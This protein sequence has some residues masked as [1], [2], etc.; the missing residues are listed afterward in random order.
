MTRSLFRRLYRA[1]ALPCLFAGLPGVVLA[2]GYAWSAYASLDRYRHALRQQTPISVETFQ[3]ALH[4]QLDTDLRRLWMAAPPNPSALERFALTLSRRDYQKLEAGAP[5]AGQHPYV[6]AELEHEGQ[7]FAAKVRLRGGRHWH[8]LGIQQSL[9]VKLDKGELVGGHRIFNLLNDPT[10]M[11][12]GEQLSLAVARD[13]G[14]LA[15]ETD[16]AR[17]AINGRDFGVF[18]YEPSGDESLLRN[19]RRMPGSIYTSE[20][21]GTAR[22]EELWSS[23]RYWTKV[24]S[25]NDSAAERADR[26]DL[27]R[28]LSAIHDA[29]GR[30]FQEFAEHELDLRAFAELDA[31]DVAF[32][33]DQRDFRENHRYYFDPYRARWE[34]IAERFRGFHED[35]LFNLVEDPLLLRLK[36]TPG[37]LSLRDRLLYEFLTGTGQPPALEARA[38]ALLARLGPELA[39]DPYW[40]AYRQ[41][42]RSD[43]FHRQ[44][45]R[46][47]T[48]ER[49]GLVVES[50]FTT[51]AHRHAQLLEALERN[52][53]Y[54]DV[55]TSATLAPGRLS[56][57]L[58]LVIDGHGGVALEGLELH[59]APDCQPGPSQLSRSGAEL[60]LQKATS[61][62]LELAQAL[63]LYPSVGI[64]ARDNP[65]LRRG[66]VRAEETPTEYRLTLSTSCRP[67][68]VV[69]WGKQLAS[70]ARVWSRPA[71]AELLARV[72]RER[73]RAEATPSFS[74]G[75]VAPHPWQL[76][77]PP[78][79]AVS[80]GPGD[81]TVAETR[82]FE[83]DQAVTV[84]PGTRLHMGPAASLVFHGPVHFAGRP[85]QPIL[86]SA[87]EQAPWGGIIIQGPASAGSELHAV[88]LTGGSR[89]SYRGGTYPALVDIHDSRDLTIDGCQFSGPATQNDILH[90]AYV[91]A[92]RLHDCSFHGGAA[93]AVDLEYAQADLERVVIIGAGDDGLDL[94]NSQVDL[95]DSL[96][97]SAS[98]NGISAGEGTLLHVRGSVIADCVVGVL[99]KNASHAELS[100][101]LLYRNATGIRTYQRTV[102]YAGQSEVTGD[103]LFVAESQTRALERADRQLDALD[104]GH[105][106]LGLPRGEA[107]GH[108]RSDVLALSDWDG[109]PAFLVRERKQAA[110]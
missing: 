103:E 105:I 4:D 36:L 54:L 110:R 7:T 57:A 67:E 75:E 53:L 87:A 88:T 58:E 13:A 29:G 96:I 28:L 78:H 42:E 73:L 104:R 38:T 76:E 64:V 74:A 43:A 31:L 94:M 69:A 89:P 92:A 61:D 63:A 14:L 2:L 71:S 66:E 70:S 3:I 80:L 107:L 91:Q 32:G 39:T 18:E 93:D 90:L 68:R 22:T 25:R 101:S 106:S 27:E 16:F 102:R 81:V 40:D 77:A 34:P 44:M 83:A 100:E 6:H 26:S 49:L 37:Y 98:D 30:A 11:V 86:V 46:P 59:F 108:V 109:L 95:R 41:L 5:H 10:P 48:L 99:A 8:T 9:K 20:L 79:P 97:V 85:E 33:G 15:P 60:A 62:R 56:T 65:S 47:N 50:E 17:V 51:Y 23:T 52:P 12:I 55:G 45:L 84:Q 19:S 1:R 21:P 72:P 82:V 24:A 35:P